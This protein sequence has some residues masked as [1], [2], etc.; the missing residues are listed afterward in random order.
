MPN[1]KVDD[2]YE[3]FQTAL[4]NFIEKKETL[5]SK[6][7]RDGGRGFREGNVRVAVNP[8]ALFRAAGAKIK[9]VKNNLSHEE[10][11]KQRE[12]FLIY[13]KYLSWL[14]YEA[15]NEENKKDPANK[16]LIDLHNEIVTIGKF[17]SKQGY[18]STF[19]NPLLLSAATISQEILT[20]KGVVPKA[21]F[22]KISEK[23]G[24]FIVLWPMYL[25][26]ENLQE[27]F[28]SGID[29][30][31]SS[32]YQFMSNEKNNIRRGSF[33][34]YKAIFEY[35]TVRQL[36][37]KAEQIVIEEVKEFS[38]EDKRADKQK[39]ADITKP[40]NPV[41]LKAP[42]K[43]V[44]N[45]MEMDL[46]PEKFKSYRIEHIDPGTNQVKNAENNPHFKADETLADGWYQYVILAK[47]GQSD[48]E[49]FRYFPCGKIPPEMAVKKKFAPYEKYVAH[50]QIAGGQDIYA[51]GAF[52]VEKGVITK[53][54]NSSGHYPT[55]QPNMDYAQKRLSDLG[56]YTK[57][58]EV[59]VSGPLTGAAKKSRNKK[60]GAA[61]IYAFYSKHGNDLAQRA[62][63]RSILPYSKQDQ[64]IIV[65][66]RSTRTLELFQETINKFKP[67][68]NAMRSVPM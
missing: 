3:R 34:D 27:C 14:V 65:Y 45:A 1:I 41:T 11:L 33:E 19:I 32:V 29:Y 52:K 37:T 10:A 46:K 63:D 35:Y 30:R 21:E 22:K 2:F 23:Q 20:Q 9:S 26:L 56:M 58:L 60:K 42:I 5:N 57:D 38:E 7:A 43:I 51:G 59:K 68:V 18:K 55:G 53:I 66:E 31:A 12:T 17:L 67:S 6:N 49:Q 40:E 28:L 4:S 25:E 8:H 13:A 15:N 64:N 48:D 62:E 39:L 16:R 24:D 54:D 61:A 44:D 36:A 47:D 50:S